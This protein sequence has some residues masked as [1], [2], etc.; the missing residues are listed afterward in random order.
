MKQALLDKGDTMYCAKCGVSNK[1]ESKF[2]AH[3][4]YAMPQE[5]QGVTSK[6]LRVKKLV[7]WLILAVLLIG[8]GGGI[9]LFQ[10][11]R[12]QQEIPQDTPKQEMQSPTNQESVE[13]PTIP[14]DQ[15]LREYEEELLKTNAIEEGS[16]ECEYVSVEW[17]DGVKRADVKGIIA[18]YVYDFDKNGNDELLVISVDEYQ[19]ERRLT[20]GNKIDLT[21]YE[22]IEDEVVEI[23]TRTVW[24]DV[25]GGSD[26]ENAWLFLKEHEGM[27][28][29]CGV[30]ESS[31]HISGEVAEGQLFALSYV[32]G[33]FVDIV[34]TYVMYPFFDENGFLSGIAKDLE[35]IGLVASADF[36]VSQEKLAY[37][38]EEDVETLLRIHGDNEYAKVNTTPLVN[39]APYNAPTLDEMKMHLVVVQ[40]F[41][42]AQAKEE[43]VRIAKAMEVRN[44]LY[45]L[46][47]EIQKIYD[48][49]I[50]PSTFTNAVASKHIAT[51]WGNKYDEVFEIAT[52]VLSREDIS[53]LDDWRQKQLHTLENEEANLSNLFGTLESGSGEA[54]KY[55]LH[56]LHARK[57]AY[58]LLQ[59]MELGTERFM[60]NMG[61]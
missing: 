21:M 1:D 55:E 6:A 50:V 30:A 47:R 13:E 44:M 58:S 27:Q 48:E 35:T 32:D 43:G 59:F 45:E 20:L 10:I 52:E 31:M 19:S 25:L 39:Y 2:C 9:F 40:I 17:G 56:Y 37:S 26:S 4:G 61:Y 23:T 57:N 24:T 46:D 34:E 42:G 15:K 49:E 7:P 12:K 29:I 60:V 53:V 11:L 54:T 22:V 14:Q 3:C 28:F 8:I 51:L 18:T 33:E 41:T 36:I 16:Y 38:T 5:E